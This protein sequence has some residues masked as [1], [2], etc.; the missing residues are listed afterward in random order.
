M[1]FFTKNQAIYDKVKKY[2]TAR[3]ATCNKARALCILDN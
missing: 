2:A 1:F 3:Q